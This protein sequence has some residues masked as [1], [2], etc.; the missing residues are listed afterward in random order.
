MVGVLI[1]VGQK[2]A[3]IAA[4]KKRDREQPTLIMHDK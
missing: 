3:L 1:V 2:C 4:A